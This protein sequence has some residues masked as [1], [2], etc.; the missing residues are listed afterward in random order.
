MAIKQQNTAHF[1]TD[2]IF[3]L[4]SC[5]VCKSPDAF[6]HLRPRKSGLCVLVKDSRMDR[7]HK[8]LP[9]SGL[10]HRKAESSLNKLN[11]DLKT[12]SLLLLALSSSNTCAVFHCVSLGR[13]LFSSRYA[14]LARFPTPN[15][16]R[17]CLG[18]RDSI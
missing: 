7:A 14:C 1:H 13:C 2:Q 10:L 17:M 4:L 18:T 16:R 15:Y 9:A 11:C 12:R 5:H 3:R 6:S 8:P